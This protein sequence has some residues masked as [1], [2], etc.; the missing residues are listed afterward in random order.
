MIATC[1]SVIKVYKMN[2]CTIIVYLVVQ[3]E[4]FPAA[5]SFSPTNHMLLM[6]CYV[7]INAG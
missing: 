3:A 7:K 1:R 5:Q 6:A 4:L 2:V